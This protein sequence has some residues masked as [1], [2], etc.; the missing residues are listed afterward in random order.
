MKQQNLFRREKTEFGGSLLESKRKDLRP[1]STKTPIFLTIKAD[2]SQSGSLLHQYNFIVNE[3][4]KWAHKFKVEVCDYSVCSNHIHLCLMITTT[5]GYKN[6]IRTFNGQTAKKIKVKWLNRPHT[7]LVKKG[8]H[9]DNVLSYIK[10]NREEA[11][12]LRPY[13]RRS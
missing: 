6:F 7:E 3:L 4:F 8:R 9:L 5:E 2:I 12:G 10:Q 1:L 11:L 13:K